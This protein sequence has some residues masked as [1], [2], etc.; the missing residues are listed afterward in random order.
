[1]EKT[2][3]VPYF[4]KDEVKCDH[5]FSIEYKEYVNIIEV[6]AEELVKEIIAGHRVY[7]PQKLG[8]FHFVK[9]KARGTDWVKTKETGKHHALPN[10]HTQKYKARFMWDKKNIPLT[11]RFIWKCNLASKHWTA[12]YEALMSNFNLIF[13]YPN[14]W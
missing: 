7:L 12:L 6:F 5:K 10:R 9:V 11:T 2:V 4:P 1:M 14:K 3:P 13:K 8:T